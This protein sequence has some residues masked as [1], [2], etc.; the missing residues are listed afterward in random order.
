MGG[1][2]LNCSLLLCPAKS[3]DAPLNCKPETLFVGG[4][5]GGG[6]GADPEP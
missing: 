5:G 6:G 2:G 4:G 1:A 3:H